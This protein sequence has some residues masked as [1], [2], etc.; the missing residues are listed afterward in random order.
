MNYIITESQLK[1]IVEGKSAMLY[2]KRLLPT[3][4]D[5]VVHFVRTTR[6]YN[7]RKLGRI[8]FIA[9]FFHLLM[10]V[11]HPYLTG[12]YG[13]DWDYDIIKKKIE[14]AYNDDVVELWE[15]IHDK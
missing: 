11:L 9:K 2:L 10:N 14:E 6:L 7:Y 1:V 5:E 4:F 15:K 8:E 13:T 12:R 3:K